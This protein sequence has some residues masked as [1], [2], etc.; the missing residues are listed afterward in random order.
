MRR[1]DANLTKG[2]ERMHATFDQYFREPGDPYPE[3][4]SVSSEEFYGKEI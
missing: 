3:I 4:V 1:H 2:L